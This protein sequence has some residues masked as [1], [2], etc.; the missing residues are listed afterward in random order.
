[1]PLF[2]LFVIGFWTHCN[3]M[4]DNLEQKKAK[5]GNKLLGMGL[6]GLLIVAAFFS[7]V[8]LGRGVP[9]DS[10]LQ[11]GLLSFFY[12]Q[13]E[14][15]NETDMAEFWRVW[16]LL[17]DKFVTSSASGT[18]DGSKK[19]EGAIAGLVESYDD[20][21]TIFLPR[22]EAEYFSE[23]ISGNFSGVGMEVGLRDRM[24][25][26]IAPLPDSPALAAGIQSGDVITRIDD[27]STEKMGIDQ[28]VRLIRGD[29]G[30]EVRLTLYREG[31]TE[32]LE[33]TIVRDT[34]SIPTLETEVVG[35][36][37]VIKL[38]SFNGLSESKMR[39]A[40]NEL[41][42]LNLKKI[43][44]DL[45]GNPG[46]FL[47]S[48][49]TIAG[50]FL[51]PG[52]VVVRENFGGDNQEEVYRSQ[53]QHVFGMNPDNFVVLIDGGSASASEILA[54]A[55]AEHNVATTMGE[56]TFGKGSVQ[57]LV[58][59]PSHSALK[60]TIAR[61]LTPEGTSFSEGG[62]EPLVAV[63]RTPEDV[64]ADTDPQLD[65]AMKWLSGD[66]NVGDRLGGLF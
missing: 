13:T 40:I 52:K 53:N 2:N 3:L 41:A 6:A 56:T 42:E 45:R 5:N 66:K 54:G 25:T 37:F 11:A 36:V 18:P 55:L 35:D 30:T 38:Y 9:T 10:P 51:E 16:N 28:A 8:Q 33:K 49:V 7:G 1:M 22:E 15:D 64:E 29:T 14:P 21:Y 23:D 62:L 31:E 20:P 65:A 57:E 26:V 32:L 58:E 24:I 17:D 47:E 46:G 27:E 44:L 34:I 63:E 61:W 43:V 12:P 60:V 19:I 48:A 39:E 4:S 59:L 50:Y